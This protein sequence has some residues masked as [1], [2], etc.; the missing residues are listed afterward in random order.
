MRQRVSTRSQAW[1]KV[2]AL[3]LFVLAVIA[4]IAPDIT[5]RLA[6]LVGVGRGADLLLYVLTV[7]FLAN[8]LM[9]YMRR[10]DDHLHL[11]QLSRQLAINLSLIHI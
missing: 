5:N 2:G 11:V 8:L 6:H 4:I 9:Q 1:G 3:L 10:Q 7:V